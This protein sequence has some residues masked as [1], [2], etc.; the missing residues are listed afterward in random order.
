MYWGKNIY[1]LIQSI[2]TLKTSVNLGNAPVFL[3][4]KS[5]GQRS[6][7]VYNPQYWRVRHDWAT[8][9]ACTHQSHYASVSIERSRQDISHLFRFIALLRFLRVISYRSI[10]LVLDRILKPKIPEGQS[11]LWT[12]LIIHPVVGALWCVP[13]LYFLYFISQTFPAI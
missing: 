5:H 13:W 9:R 8:E 12:F 6:L 11:C 1:I 10:T 7:A 4:G 3:P 2:L